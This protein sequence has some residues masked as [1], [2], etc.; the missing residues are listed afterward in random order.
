MQQT[1]YVKSLKKIKEFGIIT[2]DSTIIIETDD[3]Q[4]ILKRNREL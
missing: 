3:E 1:I 2:K 4:R